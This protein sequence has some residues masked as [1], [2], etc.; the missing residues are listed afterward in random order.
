MSD[1][2]SLLAPFALLASAPTVDRIDAPAGL[3]PQEEGVKQSG[4]VPQSAAPV[5]ISLSEAFRPESLAQVR[6]EQR[7]I[8]RISPHV[9]V[10]RVDMLTD[11]PQREMAPRY[12]ERRMSSCVPIRGIAGVQIARNNRLLLFMR[13][14][15]IVS[16]R[17]EKSCRARDFYSGFYVEN[18]DD[19]LICAGRDTLYSR[20]G[21]NCNVTKLHRLVPAED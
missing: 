8:V 13:D 12:V 20:A 6:I 21:A 11:L 10:P 3:V 16:A 14:H 9:P 7:V 1:L 15:A 4:G 17:L 19:G 2:L 18:S 5:W